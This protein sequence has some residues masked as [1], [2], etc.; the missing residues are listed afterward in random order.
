[1]AAIFN[2]GM[3]FLRFWLNLH[4]AKI[5]A[6]SNTV[7]ILKIWK[8]NDRYDIAPGELICV[9]SYYYYETNDI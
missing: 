7:L 6:Q 2:I 3:Q 1:M 4:L 8:I 9:L 5:P